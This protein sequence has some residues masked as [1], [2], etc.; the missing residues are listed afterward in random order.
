MLDFCKT[1]MT[2]MSSN[3]FQVIKKNKIYKA[4]QWQLLDGLLYYNNG[5]WNHGAW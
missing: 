4:L 2:M 3:K 5:I 1:L